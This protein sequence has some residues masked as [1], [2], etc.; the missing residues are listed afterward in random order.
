MA[1][2][3][4]MV[5]NVLAG[6]VA[7]FGLGVLLTA[8]AAAATRIEV[9]VNDQ[10]ITNYAIDQRA[11]LLTLTGTKGNARSQATEQLIDEAL[12]AQEAK[13]ANVKISD[14]Q[15]DNAFAE[16]AQRLKLSPQNFATALSQ[17]GVNPQT[18]KDRLRV[19][20]AWGQVVST[21]FRSARTVTEQDLIAQLRGKGDA[22]A[23]DTNEYLLQRVVVVIP[24][25]GS[26]SAVSSAEATARQL[27][28]R[29]TSCDTGLA[30]A[31]EANG[32]VVKSAGRRLATEIPENFRKQVEETEVGHLSAPVRTGEGLE[33]F[34]VCEKDT[35]RSTEAAIEEVQSE[36]VSEEGQIFSRQYLRNLRKDA[37]IE[38]R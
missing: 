13:R 4:G 32:V 3:T 28:G 38:R 12:Q 27:R 19:Q 9:I 36:I 35:V 31:G 5:R 24:K 33:M 16:I 8:P 20:I 21:R 22:A 37:V 18:L 1:R 14:A 34:A 17:N 7:I 6:V 2:T 23:K 11:R 15:V 30:L 25:S 29:F 26:R 10:A